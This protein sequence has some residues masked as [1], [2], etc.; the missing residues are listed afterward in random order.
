MAV[1]LNPSE[2]A[3]Y[4]DLIAELLL[5]V[6]L[7]SKLPEKPFPQHSVQRGRCEPPSLQ[8]KSIYER[9]LMLA[10][11]LI[12]LRQWESK[13][14]ELWHLRHRAKIRQLGANLGRPQAGEVTLT[15]EMLEWLPELLW[16]TLR[17]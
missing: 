14:L 4:A 3:Q 5:A 2:G 11:S 6:D 13:D 8:K 10:V 15:V 1:K 16:Y 17:F 7:A 9:M 12:N